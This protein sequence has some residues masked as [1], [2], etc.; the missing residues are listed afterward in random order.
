MAQDAVSMNAVSLDDKYE[1]ESGR[2]FLT[3]TQALVRLPMMQRQRDLAAGLNTA[4]FISG[5]RGSPLGAFD[6]QLQHAKRFVE[7]NHIKFQPGVNE[8]LAATAIWG[9]Q[10][11]D[12][13]GDFNYDGVYSIWYGKGPGVDRSGDVFKH[14]N[15]AGTAKHGGVIAL[16]GDDHMAKSSTVA[17]Q[18]EYAF[19]DAM[20]PVLNPSGVQEFLDLGIYGWAM[21]RFSGCWIAFK[22]LA[23]TVETSASVHVDPHRVQIQTPTDFQMPEGGLNIRWPDDRMEQEE[24]LMRHKLYA[25]LAFARA[26]RLD[27]RVIDN[28]EKRRLG[29]ITTGKSYLDV[30]QALDDLGI[31]EEMAAEIG[32]SL[33]KVAM[34]WPLER[35]GIREFCEGLDEVLVIEEKRALIENQVKEQLYNWHADKR[36]RIVGKFEETGEPLFPSHGELTPARIARVIAGRIAKFHDSPAIAERLDFLAKKEASLKVE[37]SATSRIPYFCSGC[38]HNTS[39]RV[40]EGSRAVAG[41]GCH[42]MVLWMDRETETF[43]Q[44]GGEGATWIGQQPFSKTKH[45]FA[46]LGDGTYFHSG[47]L[48]I[49]A[50]VGA[51][52]N[53]T[54]KILYNDAVAMTGGQHVDDPLDPA[55]ISH[56]LYAE[57]VKRIV[58]VSDEPEKYPVGYNWAKGVTVHHRSELDAIQRELREVPGVT[59]IIYDQTCAAEKR[60]RRK[61]GTFPDPDKRVFINELVCEGCGDCGVKSN[62][63]SVVPLETEFGRKRKIDQSSCNK[64]FSCVEGFC[65]SFVTVS[66]AKPKKRKAAAGSEDIWEVLP[67]PALPGLKEPYG[68]LITGIGGTGVVT[69]GALLGMAA[70]IEGKGVSILD[71]AGLA[72]KGGAVTSHV[73][74][75]ETPEDIHAVRLAAGGGRLILGADLV[76]TAAEDSRAKMRRGYTKAIVNTEE[77]ITGLF[78]SDPEYRIPGEELHDLI[79]K[80]VGPDAAEFIPSTAVATALLGDSIAANLFLLG[81]AWQKGLVPVSHEA[82]ERAIELN[83]VAVEFNKKAF[84]WGRRMAHDPERVKEIAKPEHEISD[85]KLSETLDELIE[86]RVD[87]LT[88]YQDASYAKRYAELVTKV[89]AAEAKAAPGSDALSEA[90]ARGAFKLM[91]IKDEYEVARLYTDGS[92]AEA[93]GETFEG[94]DMKLTFHMAPP[95][96]AKRDPTT[97]HL[98]KKAYGPWMLKAFGVLAKLKGLRGGPLDIFGRSEE[99]RMERQLRDDYL[100]QIEEVMLPKLNADNHG[101]A[102]ELASLAQEVRGFGHVKEA[103]VAKVKKKEAELLARFTSPAPAASAAE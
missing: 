25:A 48:A 57:G 95:L 58:A 27:R 30:R 1:L 4:C 33:Y 21:S 31:D 39:T 22:T 17:H 16:A 63:V 43:T 32:L 91:A 9:S 77:T 83:G 99:R 60:R 68:I 24:R 73:R 23:E 47:L 55:M 8:D 7:K 37:K 62:C 11:G 88:A 90:V 51:G 84:T 69:I 36:P 78:T 75:A 38:P 82:L 5:Y 10:Q 28:K 52:A 45:V 96:L 74:I 71:Q 64:D 53:I 101:A 70:H 86:R 72:Q 94:K 40:P 97:G 56:Q 103:A 35:T 44:M 6:Q 14:A 18:T 34:V 65:P 102:V 26:N 12:I 76:T 50:A 54:Y 89:R 15:M 100:A 67:E 85:R 66:G 92:F 81:Y 87:F 41:I 93:L 79:D 59:A 13:F 29:I 80:A 61:R 42:Y 2:V 46:N 19:M 49:R 98:K 20:I 3:G